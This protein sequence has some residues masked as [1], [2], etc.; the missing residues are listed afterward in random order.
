MVQKL[1]GA[2]STGNIRKNAGVNV[3]AE[4]QHVPNSADGPNTNVD[5]REQG[6]EGGVVS[7]GAN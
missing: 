1:T 7:H 3:P 5:L 2:N 4:P 6:L